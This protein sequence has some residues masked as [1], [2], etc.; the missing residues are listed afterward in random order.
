MAA[1]QKTRNKTSASSRPTLSVCMIVK[2]EEKLL[3][4]CLDSVKDIADEIVV[5][6]TGSTDKTMDIAAR[7]GAK[8]YQHPW[9]NDFSLH[10]NQSLS[11]ATGEWVLQIDA[12]EV[13]DPDT[14]S[15]LLDTIRNAPADVNGY[16]VLI[17]DVKSDGSYGVV[18]NYPRLYRRKGAKYVGRVHN[19]V[20]IP[21]KIEFSTV[22]LF[23]YGYDLDRRTMLRKFKR[24]TR[25][26]R[27]WIREKPDD[28]T[29]YFYLACGYSQ[30]QKP[31]KCI[32]YSLKTLELLKNQKEAPAFFLS[33]YYALVA[34][35]IH[36]GRLDEAEEKARE[37]LE[38]LPDYIDG[39]YQLSSISYIKKNFSDAV[40]Y[41]KR[42]LEL[43][44]VYQ[45]DPKQL[46]NLNIYTLNKAPKLKYWYGVS[47]MA[48]GEKEK[49]IEAILQ[50]MEDPFGKNTMAIEACHNSIVVS[51]LETGKNLFKKLY[52]KFHS[53]RGFVALIA[54]DLASIDYL[55]W[56]EE[57]IEEM[58]LPGPEEDELE[59]IMASLRKDW[60]AARRHLQKSAGQ[61]QTG[62]SLHLFQVL[63]ETVFQNQVGQEDAAEYNA[64]LR[65][66]Q[67]I[68]ER[69]RTRR[70]ELDRDVLNLYDSLSASMPHDVKEWLIIQSLFEASEAIQNENIELL[71][72]NLGSISH[73]LAIDFPNQFDDVQQI[74][75]LLLNISYHCDT[76][77]MPDAG[78][79]AMAMAHQFFVDTLPVQVAVLKRKIGRSQRLGGYPEWLRIV[80]KYFYP[81]DKNTQRLVDDFSRTTVPAPAVLEVHDLH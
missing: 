31:D 63:Q 33:T 70:K 22:R 13:L 23:H 9:Q 7:Y 80:L 18:F 62:E 68:V 51:D 27:K 76:G 41:G 3:G 21:G 38:I 17:Q 75:Q 35:L 48:T 53:D 67:Q 72:L 19:Q 16:M 64:A 36:R 40:K 39:Y 20:V 50:A 44:E 79:T 45:K 58:P 34:A 56:L 43:L 26:L 81:T 66:Y 42:Y 11:Y 37:S 47:L 52:E 74:L 49:G 1:P 55:C 6:D 65:F 28:P 15:A 25:L 10:R 29:P 61:S 71:L 14:K 60:E 8:I 2:N 24:T 73:L 78:L 57:W 12:D 5:V 77:A 30:Y 59:F 32:E 69:L 46:G 54:Q 4:K